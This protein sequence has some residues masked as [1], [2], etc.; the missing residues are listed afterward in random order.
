MQCSLRSSKTAKMMVGQRTRKCREYTGPAPNSVAIKARPPNKVPPEYLILERRRQEDILKRNEEQ[1]MYNKLC[2]LKNEWERW[3]DKKILIG[4]VKREVDRRVRGF[5]FDLEDRKDKLRA[6]LRKEDA[7]YTAEMEAAEETVLE[8]QAKMRE[9]AKFLKEKRE[10]ERLQFVQDKLDQKFRSECEE[11]RS[12]LSKQNQDMVCAERLEQ[13]RMKEEQAREQKEFEDM[14]ADLWERDRQQK[15]NRE[16][17]EAKAAH[18]RNRETLDV[19]RK[20]MAALETQKE[21]AKALQQEELQLMREQIALRKMEE[22]AAAEEKRRRQQEM[23][24]MLDL[25]LKMK[26]QKKARE[27]QEQLAFDLK[28]LEQLLE[29]SRNEAMEQLQRKIELKEEDRRYREYL[30]RLMEEEK[31]KEQELERLIAG[32]VESAWQ[33]KIEQWRTERIM[34]KKLLEEVMA[35]RDRQ[36]QERLEENR[37]QKEENE[38]ERLHLL[39]AIEDNRRYEMEQAAKRMATSLQYQDDLQQQIN[40]NVQVREEQVRNDEYEHLMGMQA[41]KE[42]REKLKNALD[43]PVFDRLHPIRRVMQNQQ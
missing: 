34:R 31:R 24:D 5:A 28:M 39:Q 36:I 13:L 42:Y 23:R 37:R 8:R 33:R 43:N 27:E 19:L 16:E 22:A 3:T 17:R 30:R 32:E 7:E 11:L 10:A 38:R 6:L 12:T 35:G 41:E 18:E 26:M 9:R 20:Q 29:E 1:T 15:M 21:E 2:D 14:Y 25:T 4:N 40:Y